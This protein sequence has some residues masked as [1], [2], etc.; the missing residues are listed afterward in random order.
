MYDHN[1]LLYRIYT[2]EVCNVADGYNGVNAQIFMLV[3]K[4]ATSERYVITFPHQVDVR[5][6]YHQGDRLTAS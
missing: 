3:I 6:V 1:I 5:I 2:D 4:P